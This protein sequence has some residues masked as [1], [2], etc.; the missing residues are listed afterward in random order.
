MIRK[1]VNL[2]VVI[3]FDVESVGVVIGVVFVFFQYSFRIC[4]GL[5]VQYVLCCYLVFF[6]IVLCF[7]YVGL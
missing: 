4:F 5:I 6:F 1:Y 2:L 3:I 7:E